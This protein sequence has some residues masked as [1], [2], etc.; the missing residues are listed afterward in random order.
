MSF[1]DNIKKENTLSNY[2][3]PKSMIFFHYHIHEGLKKVYLNI[4]DHADL[5]RSLKDRFDHQKIVILSKTRYEWMF[6]RLQDFKFVSAYN[7]TIFRISSQLKLCRENI[8][9]E[10]MTEKILYFS[11]FEC[12]PTTAIS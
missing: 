1:G 6:L 7:S 3:N 4:K 9:D 10:D 5:W 11:R 8:T 2:D 12:A